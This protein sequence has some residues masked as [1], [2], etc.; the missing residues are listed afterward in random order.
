MFKRL[1]PKSFGRSLTECTSG[2]TP[3]RRKDLSKLVFKAMLGGAL[4]SWLTASIAGIMISIPD[5][6]IPK[7]FTDYKS[8]DGHSISFIYSDQNSGNS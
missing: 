4:A 6:S 2:Y 1:D 7:V 5:I 8:E 3:F